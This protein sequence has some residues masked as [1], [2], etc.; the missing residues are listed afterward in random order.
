MIDN[1]CSFLL[2][3][4]KNSGVRATILS[5]LLSAPISAKFTTFSLVG[6]VGVEPTVTPT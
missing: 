6:V 5:F 4:Q 2:H 1:L 3:V